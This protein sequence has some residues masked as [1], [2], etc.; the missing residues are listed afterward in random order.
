VELTTWGG[1]TIPFGI[2][3][4]LPMRTT[5]I[6]LSI[7]VA[8]NDRQS[9][10]DAQR[11]NGSYLHMP[12]LSCLLIVENGSAVKFCGDG[13]DPFRCEKTAKSRSLSSREGSDPIFPSSLR[14]HY[15]QMTGS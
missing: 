12:S 3:G 11:K 5:W 14:P 2:V 8:G 4:V 6:E 7:A 10:N 9:G 1:A 13:V 15:R